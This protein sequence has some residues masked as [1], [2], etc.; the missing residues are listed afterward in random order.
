MLNLRQ[1]LLAA[2]LLAI[3]SAVDAAPRGAA[4]PVFKKP[5]TGIGSPSD[6]AIRR[7]REMSTKS[8]CGPAW[9][10]QQVESYNGTLGPTQAF[11]AR[12]ESRVGYHVDVGCTGTLISDDLFL[13]AGHCGYAVGHTVRFD[14]QNAPGGSPARPTRDFTVSQVVEQEES[15]N[16]DY[17]I[18]RLNGSPG[19]E[20][21]HANIA[22]IDPP[23][24]A[25]ATMIGH[26][27]R[28]PKEIHSATVFD[29]SS[30]I[31]PNWFRHQI[32][33]VGGNSGSGVLNA[34][35]QVI[36]V[37]TNA[38]CNTTGSIQGNSAM[39]MS[40]L[41][42]RS[43][44]LQTLT[45]NK[46]LWQHGSGRISLWTLN[47]A[48]DHLSYT[49]HGPFPGWTPVSYSGNRMLWRNADGR[50]SYWVLN[51]QNQHL[52]YVE[53]GPFNGW[54]PVNHANDRVLWRHADG[55]ISLWTVDNVGNYV[56]HREYGPYAGWTALNYAN[57][58][59]LWRH[60]SGKISLWRMDDNNNGVGYME[61]GP[62]TGWTALSYANGEILWRHSSGKTSLWTLNRA[63][64]G[65]SYLE[66]GPFDGWTPIATADRKLLW[67]HS[68]GKITFW[69]VNSDGVGLGY[70]EHGPFSGWNALFTTG[71]VP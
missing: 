54:T 6:I 71:A 47:A 43:P 21:G 35:G 49:E 10:A 59:I 69:T 68:T 8:Q 61:Y 63:G 17:A 33:T 56:S 24:G 50:S 44:T 55:R 25:Q 62:Y 13:S 30:P 9:D 46:I 16:W 38:G 42:T 15:A 14:Y 60:A 1:T 26:P 41:V 20:F 57:N 70:R 5:V 58:R 28:R 27:N 66:N 64:V 19:R 12:H 53:N 2:S 4:E 22:A 34:D 51:D 37:H 23:A 29:Y 65:L 40:R 31:G 67:Q 48:G 52:T 32:D 18:V 11:V 45:R 3:G 36:G 39:R 7:A